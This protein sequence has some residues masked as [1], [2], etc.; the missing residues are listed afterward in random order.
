MILSHSFDPS[1]RIL[2]SQEFL[3]KNSKVFCIADDVREFKYWL[4][5][6]EF[7][8]GKECQSVDHIP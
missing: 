3:R 5:Y 1:V 4:Q 2:A 8:T 7:L 6:S